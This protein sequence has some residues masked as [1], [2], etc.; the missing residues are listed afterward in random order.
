MTEAPGSL[1]IV[2]YA[3]PSTSAAD[4]GPG[5]A[6]IERATTPRVLTTSAIELSRRTSRSCMRTP[7][8]TSGYPC[9]AG[10]AL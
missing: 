5:A 10:A 7:G 6:T 4:D 2:T 8:S 1:F 3:G 9:P